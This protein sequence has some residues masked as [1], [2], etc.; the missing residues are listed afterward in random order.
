[1]GCYQWYQPSLVFYCQREV[2]QLADPEDMLN[3]LR[4]PLPVYLFLPT[5]TWDAMAGQVDVPYRLVA[6]HWDFYRHCDVLV[7]T[8]RP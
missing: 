4:E 5:R 8:N 6:H 2:V 1:V 7:V 3:F